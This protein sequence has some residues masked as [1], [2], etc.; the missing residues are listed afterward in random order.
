MRTFLFAGAMAV[1]VSSTSIRAHEI[2]TSRVSAVFRA[3]QPY[4]I[5]IVTDAVALLEK[6]EAT[7]GR[8]LPADTSPAVVQALLIGFDQQFR[9]RVAVMFDGVE[10]SPRISYSVVPPVDS[11]SATVAT[12]RLTGEIPASARNF[13]WKYAWTFA[14][15]ALS[16]RTTA[17]ENPSIQWLEG[18]DGSK[19]IILAAAPKPISRLLT[20]WRYL[21]LGYTHILPN[22]LDHILFVLGIFL[23]SGRARS[24][25]L[26][27]SAFTVAH[28]ITLGLSTYGVVTVSPRIVEP[29][30]A[31]SIA[32][33]ALENVFLSELK[34]WR[35]ALV[36]A[37]GLLHGLGFAGA[38]RELGLRRSEFLTALVTF[39]LGVE[40]GQL[41]V[42]AAAFVVVGWHC[43]DRIWYRSR[44]VVP[45]SALIALTA[46]YWTVQR[47]LL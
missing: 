33:V 15:Y 42:I 10:V 22:G 8:P 43:A 30:I 40:A 46:I 38:L 23:L 2:G 25:L 14:S 24:V 7:N 12:I 37:F 44:I 28:S 21:A 36:F 5:E 32:Y 45:A 29:M 35:V 19:P 34:S 13:T 16:V 20:A 1:L 26:Q 39:N 41:S 27:V 9:R 4:K 17:S 18:G 6:L 3:D 47:L 31:I 11:T